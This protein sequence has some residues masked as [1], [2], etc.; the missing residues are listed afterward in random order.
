MGTWDVP[1][2]DTTIGGW[3]DVALIQAGTT[4]GYCRAERELGPTVANQAR[5]T[6]ADDVYQVR[7]LVIDGNPWVRKGWEELQAVKA[8][9]RD[10]LGNGGIYVPTFDST[11][12]RQIELN[13]A[14]TTSG[15]TMT[16][17]V[18]VRPSDLSQIPD[19]FHMGIVHRAIAEGLTMV[20]EDDDRA[21]WHMSYFDNE[22]EKLRRLA[23]AEVSS[24][25]QQ[26][27][28]AGYH[29]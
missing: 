16:A 14:P 12:N 21:A 25:S 17:L 23:N 8:G 10:V 6:L 24:T 2:G 29:F 3:I 4:S 28:I 7:D 9:L 27:L 1:G 5:Y 11:G 13:P 18:I 26:G 22:V 15:S 19:E 20:E